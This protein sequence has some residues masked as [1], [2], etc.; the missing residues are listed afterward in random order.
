VGK[1]FGI[2]DTEREAVKT[3]PLP[4]IFSPRESVL[5]H[6]TDEMVEIRSSRRLIAIPSFSAKII[7]LAN[8]GGLNQ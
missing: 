4:A 2:T 6:L 5:L 3:T 7:S 1:E 8:W